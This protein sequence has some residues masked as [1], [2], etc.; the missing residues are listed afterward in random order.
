M[1][2]G[3]AYD[4][5]TGLGSTAVSPEI[6]GMAVAVNDSLAFIGA[7]GGSPGPNN[8]VMAV[9]NSI[10]NSFD[11]TNNQVFAVNGGIASVRGQADSTARAINGGTV[12]ERSS[13]NSTGTAINIGSIA[14]LNFDSN[15]RVMAVNGG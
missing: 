5:S 7:E 10:A 11:T 14:T 12:D 2:K 4:Y 8:R 1:Q 9:N 15:S 13:T 3:P 6:G